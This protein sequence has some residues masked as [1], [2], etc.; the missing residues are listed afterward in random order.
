MKGVI[1][2]SELKLVNTETKTVVFKKDNIIEKPIQKY[3][4]SYRAYFSFEDIK[5]EYVDIILQMKFTLKQGDKT[6]EY[7]AEIF[8]EKI[9]ENFVEL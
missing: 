9:I 1:H 7:K 6:S 2:I 5:L 3:A 4:N 8:F